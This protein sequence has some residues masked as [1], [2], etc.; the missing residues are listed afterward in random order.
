MESLNKL[1]PRVKELFLYRTKR[2]LET[3]I[4]ENIKGFAEY[5]KVRFKFRADPRLIAVEG[6]CNECKSYSIKEFDIIEYM[7]KLHSLHSQP[8]IEKCS[9]CKG[10]RYPVEFPITI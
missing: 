6:R 1:D 5:E 10:H 2:Y 9:K 4:E 3:M 8:L 7:G